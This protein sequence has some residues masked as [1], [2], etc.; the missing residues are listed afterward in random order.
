MSIFF[1]LNRFR[2]ALC[3]KDKKHR[4]KY[5]C[6]F[7]LAI[8]DQHKLKYYLD[9]R[10]IFM[11]SLEG[12]PFFKD[13]CFTMSHKIFI[14]L[15]HCHNAREIYIYG[16]IISHVFNNS[17]AI[18]T[19]HIERL[20]AALFLRTLWDI[21]TTFV[22]VCVCACVRTCVRACVRLWCMSI[23]LWFNRLCYFWC[24][25]SLSKVG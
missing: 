9:H 5:V 21:I 4:F 17:I 7:R 14:V 2:L 16:I 19:I 1:I 25:W 15:R 20:Y 24:V 6:M 10:F 13:F 18:Y 11:F 12:I 22:C 8:W 3:Y 23:C